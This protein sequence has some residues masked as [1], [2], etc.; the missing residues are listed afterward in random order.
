MDNAS[1][2]AKAAIQLIVQAPVAAPDST[3]GALINSI[4][5]QR[6]EYAAEI[7]VCRDGKLL[8]LLMVEDLLVASPETPVSALMRPVPAVVMPYVDQE[9]ATLLAVESGQLLIGVVGALFA[10]DVVGAFEGQ[11]ERNLLLAF[12]VPSIVYLADAVGTQTE[13][14]VVRGLSVGIALRKV[15]FREILTG[16]FLGLVLSLA[17]FPFI[18][19]RWGA[20]DVA[21]SVSISLLAASTLA[22][23][24]AMALPWVFHRLAKDP[25]FGSGPLA[26]VIQDILSVSIY[27]AISLALVK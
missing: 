27:F 7:A 17:I 22:T 18:L 23:V 1:I 2:P 16:L 19:W 6:F 4:G 5:T 10:A 12:F 11:L 14:L 3:V 25:A 8:G 13:T 20:T 9:R 15:V 26:T 21:V 24:I